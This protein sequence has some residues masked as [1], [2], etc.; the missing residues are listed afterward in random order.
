MP[1]CKN[2]L[3][4]ALRMPGSAVRLTA[5]ELAV[6]EGAAADEEEL[7]TRNGLGKVGRGIAKMGSRLRSTVGDLRKASITFGSPRPAGI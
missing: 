2:L 3:Q 6:A 7:P 4:S 1:G 5:A